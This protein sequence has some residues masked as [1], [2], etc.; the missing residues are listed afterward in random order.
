MEESKYSER[1]NIASLPLW[2]DKSPLLTELDVEL[3]ER[4]NNDCIHC[5]INLPEDDGNAK[6]RELTTQEIKEIAKE[7]A[8]LGCLVIRLTGGEPLLREDFEEI[9][10]HIR[11]L[12]IKVLLFTNA[13]LITPEIV[14]LFSRIPPL[15]PIEV[16]VY[17]MKKRSY[18]AVSR[19]PG[20]FEKA[21]NGINLLLENKIPF[22]VKG[23]VLPPNRDEVEE[24]IQWSKTIPWMDGEGV[25]LA[26]LLDLR[27]RRD[28]KKNKLI[29]R[30][31]L[32]P[33]EALELFSKNK[34]E[35]LKSLKKFCS[36]FIGVTGDKLI[37]CGAGI[38]KACVDAY[39]NLQLCM[40]LR[41][42]DT[43]YN[44]RE[45]SLEDALKNFFPKVREL[46]AKNPDYLSRCARCF[47]KGLCEQCPGKSWSEHG[48][49]DTP[50][51]YL[52]EYAH[53]QGEFL[54]LLEKGEKAWEVS[55]WQERLKR[56][57]EQMAE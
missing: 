30:L 22:V 45:G 16:S 27:T 18:E 47:L 44:L 55:D 39:G 33:A 31:R 3:T 24:L 50:V 15:K 17:G 13:T 25:P 19:V 14:R 46:R 34:E 38:D 6:A 40:L 21:W 1:V 23:T 7:A 4:C 26:V 41:H 20:S 42:P 49:L 37:T 8:S 11:K 28:E 48:T 9:Y 54:G 43:T 56:L 53:L 35:Y 10:V 12:G 29:M 51:E 2:K 57:S 5:Y 36:K 32:S 52:C